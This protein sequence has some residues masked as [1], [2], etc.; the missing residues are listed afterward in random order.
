MV[1]LVGSGPRLHMITVMPSPLGSPCAHS[2]TACGCRAFSGHCQAPSNITK[3]TQKAGSEDS[4]FH[5]IFKTHKTHIPYEFYKHSGESI[6]EMLRCLFDEIWRSERVP[7][8]W[9][10]CNIVLLH[11]GGHKIM[12][13]LKNYRPI[14]LADTVS[15]I[16]CEI[17]DE[18]M[19]HVVE[20]QGVM[21]EEQN[22]FR[23]DRRGEDNLFVI[24]TTTTTFNEQP[25][26]N[27]PLHRFSGPQP[28]QQH[29][30]DRA[31]PATDAAPHHL[32]LKLRRRR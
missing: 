3:P 14:A 17:L 18:R 22:G 11:K 2:P 5:G 28:Q 23:K 4:E 7:D 13:E 19:K 32:S 29:V 6:I 21:G 8:E 26:C 15:K 24:S 30:Y 31:Q 9:N 1:Y 12:K 10:K 27:L 20:E 25:T 16:F